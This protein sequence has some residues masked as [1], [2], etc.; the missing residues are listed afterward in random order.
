MA[1]NRME[2]YL[3]DGRTLKGD[4]CSIVEFG[5]RQTPGGVL[6]T[7]KEGDHWFEEFFPWTG[8]ASVRWWIRSPEPPIKDGS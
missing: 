4:E 1:G 7:Y 8:I 2:L 5:W 3:L 6:S